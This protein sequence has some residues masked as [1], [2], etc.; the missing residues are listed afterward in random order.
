M[1]KKIRRICYIGVICILLCMSLS[2]CKGKN[3]P[4]SNYSFREYSV[5]YD[6]ISLHMDSTC[7]SDFGKNNIILVHGLTYSSHEFDINYKDYSLV[8]F[9]ADK[10]YTVW[11]LDIAGYGQ[12]ERPE[13][14][15]VVNSE[16]AA[17][18]IYY[19][20]KE[21]CELTGKSKIDVLGWSWGTITTSKFVSNHPE[22]VNKL[23]LYAPI[24]SG[25]GEG[26][27][28]TDY[29]KNSWE[30]AISDFQIKD[31][32]TIDEEKVEPAIVEYFA[33]SC[34]KYDGESSPNG[35]RKDLFVDESIALIDM[36]KIK[37]PTLLIYGDADPYLNYELID[38]TYTELPEGSMRKIISGAAHCAYIEKPYYR[39]FR[40]TVIT[41]LR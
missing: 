39:E 4:D 22:I 18:N 11:R 14:G 40:N 8:R 6:D 28:D 29:H 41:F 15:L 38:K 33:S 34:W 19:A 25:I 9:L 36:S 27:I 7:K 37:I 35:P 2:G 10:G 23:V 12:S 26:S 24:V 20:V 1:M 16:Y 30:N 3:K 5:L 32:G 31:D 13:D 17:D 21:I